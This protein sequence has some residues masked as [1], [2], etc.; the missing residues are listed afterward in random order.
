MHAKTIEMQGIAMNRSR[1]SA[2]ICRPA[3]L[4]SFGC[5][6]LVLALLVPIFPSSPKGAADEPGREAGIVLVA[7][8]P[9]GTKEYRIPELDQDNDSQTD[10]DESYDVPLETPASDPNVEEVELPEPSALVRVGTAEVP[11]QASNAS[12]EQLFPKTQPSDGAT[13]L[14]KLPSG[15]VRISVFGVE[16]EGTSFAFVFDRSAS[17]GRDGALPLRAARSELL[18]AIDSLDERHRF[19]ILSFNTHI[20]TMEPSRRL[21]IADDR[22]KRKATRFVHSVIESLGT[23]YRLAVLEG[24]KIGADVMFFLTDGATNGDG[25]GL[26]GE[27]LAEVRAKNRHPSAI[28]V[29]QFDDGTA[30]GRASS[31]LQTLAEENG[32]QYRVVP[33][34]AR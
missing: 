19:Q 6:L 33:I 34:A 25:P 17:M 13:P 20:A 22:H 15:R 29:I 2:A 8:K 26:T 24:L 3:W 27:L 10:A 23:D 9:D 28:H 11:Q 31:L 12:G 14:G 18:A 1:W 4:W 21:V 7:R 16:G 5:H 32:G 30:A